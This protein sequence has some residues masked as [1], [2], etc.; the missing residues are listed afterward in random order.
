MFYIYMHINTLK[1]TESINQQILTVINSLRNHTLPNQ[2]VTSV[3]LKVNFTH[4]GWLIAILFGRIMSKSKWKNHCILCMNGIVNIT[5]Y[6]AKGVFKNFVLKHWILETVKEVK[7]FGY[8]KIFIRKVG[9]LH[10]SYYT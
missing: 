8:K 2:W 10:A 7:A 5:G 9:L 4:R 1:H 3:Q 6:I